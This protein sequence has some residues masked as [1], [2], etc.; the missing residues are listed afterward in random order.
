MAMTSQKQ[1]HRYSPFPGIVG[2][3]S[4]VNDV[5]N[6]VAL[7]SNDSGP[8]SLNQNLDEDLLSRIQAK[9]SVLSHL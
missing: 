8:Y 9:L 3:G 4:K 1:E 7:T 6:R 2:I 5:G